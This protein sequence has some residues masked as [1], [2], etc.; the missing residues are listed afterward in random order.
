MSI[1]RMKVPPPQVLIDLR[2]LTDS[3]GSADA[4]VM[5]GS[6]PQPIAPG[7]ARCLSD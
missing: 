7:G 5:A 4:A 3:A 2:W 6:G 1:M